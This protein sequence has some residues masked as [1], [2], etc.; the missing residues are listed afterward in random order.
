[1]NR[2]LMLAGHAP[3]LSVPATVSA[4]AAAP[5]ARSARTRMP[6]RE[7]AQR[8]RSTTMLLAY[9]L[10][11]ATVARV[12]PHGSMCGRGDAAGRAV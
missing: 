5:G 6:Y 3:R 1:M 8:I 4:G 2:V 10:Q 12:S 11:R 7:G 9:G